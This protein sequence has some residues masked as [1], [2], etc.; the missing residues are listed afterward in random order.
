MPST[1]LT[2]AL[3]TRRVSPPRPPGPAVTDP[4][5]PD[6]SGGWTLRW[7]PLAACPSFGGQPKGVPARQPLPVAP[8]L[9][10][11]GR[12][13]QVKHARPGVSRWPTSRSGWHRREGPLKSPG[14]A[15]ATGARADPPQLPPVLLAVCPQPK[16][17]A[18][19]VCHT[20]P[21]MGVAATGRM[22]GAVHRAGLHRLVFWSYPHASNTQSRALGLLTSEEDAV[23]PEETALGGALRTTTPAALN[24]SIPHLLTRHPCIALP[25]SLLRG[26]GTRVSALGVGEQ[27]RRNAAAVSVT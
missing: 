6:S 8:L 17:A 15:G 19:K 22:C 13:P 9:T 27:R 24:S 12:G 10:L 2:R 14:G 11:P 1:S 18:A 5:E 20:R 23:P 25:P 3:R 4:K 21:S 26:S 7:G 16:R